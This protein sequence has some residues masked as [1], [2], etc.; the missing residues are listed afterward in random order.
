MRKINV[1]YPSVLI[2]PLESKIFPHQLLTNMKNCITLLDMMNSHSVP[3]LLKILTALRRS[4]L[5]LMLT[6]IL[7]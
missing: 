5:C 6:P 4:V 1:K 2:M 3:L 7:I